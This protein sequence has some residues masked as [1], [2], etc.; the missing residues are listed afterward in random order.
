MIPTST[1]GFWESA[2]MVQRFAHRDPDHRL[3][4]LIELYPNPEGVRILDLGCAGG[5]NTVLLG[6][7]GFDVMAVD[8]S[9]AMVDE[10]RR[11]L[12]EVLGSRDA[13]ARVRRGRMDDLGSFDSGSMDLVV[14]L[15]VLHAAGS[16]SEWD[17]T[18]E[19]SFRVLARGGRLLVANHGP[20]FLPTGVDVKPVPGEP[21]LYDGL[22][23]GRSFLIEAPEL[24]REMARFGA[25]PLVP[26]RTVD[27]RTE[28]G[29]RR[30]TVNGLYLK[31]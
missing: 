2:E 29:G 4:E 19:E 15:G 8:A 1:T 23:S 31:P 7:R 12:G 22:P 11:R 28:D 13:E 14:A 17:R 21:G 6:Q 9:Q 16:R 26:T 10:T 5:R 20:G 24:D 25:Y 30:V 18:L 3:L 27:R